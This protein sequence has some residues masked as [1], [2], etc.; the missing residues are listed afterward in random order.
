MNVSS[1]TNSAKCMKMESTST[2]SP[3]KAPRTTSKSPIKSKQLTGDDA[4][5]SG[6][7]SG[8]RKKADPDYVSPTP[9]EMLEKIK[10]D[11]KLLKVEVKKEFKVME[12]SGDDMKQ[13]LKDAMAKK[14][15]YL[16]EKLKGN[17]LVNIEHLHRM[18]F[19]NEI[20]TEYFQKENENMRKNVKNQEK[21]SK[22]DKANI[23]KML[24]ING[25]SEKAVTAALSAGNQLRVSQQR[26]KARLEQAKLAQY[27]EES[28]VEHKKGQRDI[29]II[30]NKKDKSEF[31]K[32]LEDIVRLIMQ[33]CK[34]EKVVAKVLKVAGKC[35]SQD[36]GLDDSSDSS[37]CSSSFS[38]EEE[39][40]KEDQ[41]VAG[42]C[43]SQD[44]GLDDSSDSSSSSDEEEDKKKDKKEDKKEVK[45]QVDEDDV[46]ISS[47]SS[48]SSSDFESRSSSDFE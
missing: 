34:D 23:Q 17:E 11:M 18:G 48:C 12:S 40:K 30:R 5:E 28:L 7:G 24:Q 9:T 32:S 20:M 33:R 16:L 15:E 19:T 47:A 22:N 3:S 8:K 1:N 43:L 36:A 2:I 45:Q 21:E 44:A 35:L 14:R 26:L 31:K 41:K 38:D 4:L 46:S 25:E 39:D 42:K 37:S 13:A 29:E 27:A 10:I 6:S